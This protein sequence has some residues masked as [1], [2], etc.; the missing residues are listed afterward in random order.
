MTHREAY[1][2]SVLVALKIAKT[3]FEATPKS[4]I[5]ILGVIMAAVALAKAEEWTPEQLEE[6]W[7]AAT[8]DLYKTK[9]LTLNA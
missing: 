7:Q 4:A 3:A 6:A 2:Q 8:S 1:D 9:P 5:G